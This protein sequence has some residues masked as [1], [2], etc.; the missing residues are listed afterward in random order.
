MLSLCTLFKL[1]NDFWQVQILKCL[2]TLLNY[3]V[4]EQAENWLKEQALKEG[5]TKAQKLQDRP[6]S[7]GLVGV[8]LNNNIAALVEVCMKLPESITFS[9]KFIKELCEIQCVFKDFVY[10]L[11]RTH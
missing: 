10:F 8:S 6:M 3:P 2:Y 7:Q 9:D 5:W 1:C 4:F 11:Y